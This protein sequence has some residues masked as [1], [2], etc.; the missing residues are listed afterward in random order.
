LQPLKRSPNEILHLRDLLFGAFA[1]QVDFLLEGVFLLEDLP[2][3]PFLLP[4]LPDDFTFL[5]SALVEI[6]ALSVFGGA[7]TLLLLV[8]DDIGA[9]TCKLVSGFWT[10]FSRSQ[11]GRE[12]VSESAESGL[13]TTRNS[14]LVAKHY[15]LGSRTLI[16]AGVEGS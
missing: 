4:G 15:T 12:Q 16:P 10:G 8:R 13:R 1:E 7:G 11:I 14:E 6:G 2:E 9:V 3:S 5:F